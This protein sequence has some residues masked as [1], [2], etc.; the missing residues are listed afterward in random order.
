MDKPRGPLTLL[1][2]SRK[3]RR[4]V[5]AV[6]T[7]P[8]LLYFGCLGPACWITAQPFPNG[9]Y[10][11]PH[12]IMGI[13]SPLGDM[14]MNVKSPAGAAVRWW[15]GLG[16]GQGS[17]SGFVPFGNAPQGSGVVSIVKTPTGPT[18]LYY[19]PMP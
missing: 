17:R 9:P 5:V 15:M 4:W 10:R 16:V 18:P 13:Y 3:A 8:W 19:A 1:T 2:R 14:A 11:A 7:L 12:G 6:A